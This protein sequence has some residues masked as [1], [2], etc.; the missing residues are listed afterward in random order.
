MNKIRITSL[1][2]NNGCITVNKYLIQAIGL[3]EAV[4]YCELCSRYEY[5]EDKEMLDDGYFYNTQY[6]LQAGT[7]LGEKAQRTVISKLKK[8]NLI[9]MVR[10]GIPAKRYFTIIDDDENLLNLLS[11]GKEKLKKLENPIDTSIG[12]NLK[13]KKKEQ[14]IGER[15]GNN[16]NNDTKNN[17]KI[18][19]ILTEVENSYLYLKVINYYLDI[20]KSNIGKQHPELKREHW[21][22]VIDALSTVDLGI[23]IEDVSEYDEMA[24]MNRHF[25]TDY[26]KDGIYCDYNILH[27]ISGDIRK[28]RYYEEL[29]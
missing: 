15:S 6:D 4:L 2:R 11:I 10:K 9:D 16:T 28:N 21:I 19:G 14:A 18:K 5:F 8:L 23:S 29:Y 20:Y 24:M 25:N 22:S 26:K 17:T 12:G 3:S 1:L 7:G 13:R 27:Y